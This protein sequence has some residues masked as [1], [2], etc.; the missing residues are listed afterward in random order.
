MSFSIDQSL[1]LMIPRV[2]P[3]WID[4]QT[5]I[6]IFHQQHLGRVYKVSIIRVPDSKKRSFPIYKAILYFSAWY[7]NTIAYHFQQRIFGAKK[8]ARV[9]YDDPWY[10]VVFENKT[11]RL[12]NNDKR[13]MRLGY[14]AYLHEQVIAEQDKRIQD[15]EEFLKQFPAVPK[16]SSEPHL[17][18]NNLTDAFAM[19]TLGAELKLTET[20]INVAEAALYEE[21]V[22][23]MDISFNSIS[24]EWTESGNGSSWLSHQE[25]QLNAAVTDILGAE[26]ALTETAMNVAESV[27]METDEE[28]ETELNLT[29]TAIRVAEAALDDDE[30]YR[31]DYY[32][33]QEEFDRAYYQE[34]DYDY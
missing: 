30:Q 7:D 15:L 14:Q 6:D 16:I 31:D 13:L 21:E 25:T 9:V 10:W 34:Q 26:L 4:E 2:F 1:S 24:A 3:Q 19:D 18:W 11:R 33:S 27:L 17:V 12:S 8:Q 28:A 20:A 23:P 22:S 5:I 32:S 29:E